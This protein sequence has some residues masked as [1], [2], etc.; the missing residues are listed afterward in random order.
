MEWFEER[1]ELEAVARMLVDVELLPAAGDVVEFLA[2]PWKWAPEREAWIGA[3][4]PIVDDEGWAL[5]AARL[6]RTT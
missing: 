6:E 2:K 5:F 3:G 1:A 4:R